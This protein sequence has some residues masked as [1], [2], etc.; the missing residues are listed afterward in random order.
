VLPD[1]PDDTWMMIFGARA[2]FGYTRDA[3]RNIVWFANVPESIELSN[4]AIARTS[5]DDWKRRLTDLF[6]SDAGPACA[7]IAGTNEPLYVGNTYDLQHVPSWYAGAAIIVGDAAHATSPSSGQGASMAIEDGVVLGK[8][9]RDLPSIPEAFA[10]YEKLRRARVEQ[11]V[12]HGA[13]LSSSKMPGRIGRVVRDLVLPYFLRRAA[14]PEAHGWLYD[15]HVEWDR[16]VG[17]EA[18]TV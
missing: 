10:A 2:F 3:A 7:I 6:S 17:L 9:L 12:A 15:F 13:R 11:I 14:T 1:V 8:C 4:T 16:R 18:V 5:D